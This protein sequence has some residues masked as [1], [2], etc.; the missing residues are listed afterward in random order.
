MKI[1]VAGVTGML[2]QCLAE[3]LGRCHKVIG[4]SNHGLNHSLQCD[5][6]NADNVNALFMQENP[7]LIIHSAGYTD[8]DG[9]ETNPSWAQARNA[10][11]AKH[12]AMTSALKKI[13]LIYISTDYVFSGQKGTPY[14]EADAV[15][16]VNIYGM[17][18]L[19]GE[20]WTKL[21][22]Y[23]YAIVRTSWLFGR[24]NVHNFVNIISDK[25]KRETLLQ[26][27]ADQVNSPTYTEDLTLAIEKIGAWLVDQKM[28]SQKRHAQTFHVA[29]QG[30]TT[31]HEMAL[32]MKQC[33]PGTLAQV[34]KLDSHSIKGRKAIRPSYSAMSCSRYEDC[35]KHTMRP[36]TQALKE[37]LTTKERLC[38]SS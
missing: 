13:P 8:V 22:A 36:W 9:C 26:V 20:V 7:D 17:T 27:L 16:P 11:T 12:L 6:S 33:L 37:Y 14:T 2:G 21:A 32:F 10:L 28:R 35:F 5:L 38:V 31:R 29:N 1:L 15:F 30:Q 3:R 24:G 18:K 4:V 34:S 23:S 19:Q 25:L